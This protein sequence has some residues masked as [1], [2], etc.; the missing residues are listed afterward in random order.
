MTVH[1]FHRTLVVPPNILT[2][3]ADLLSKNTGLSLTSL[4]W[5]S[6]SLRL[7]VNETLKEYGPNTEWLVGYVKSYAEFDKE[8]P[9]GPRGP[10]LGCLK[11]IPA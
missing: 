9:L 10:S 4:V 7:S 11:N 5:V 6:T 1:L 8:L 2:T 3:M